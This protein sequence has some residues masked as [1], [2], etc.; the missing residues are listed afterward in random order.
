MIVSNRAH[1]IL[2]R[3]V[4]FI[5]IGVLVT[6]IVFSQING[7]LSYYFQNHT[8]GIIALIGIVIMASIRINYFSYEDEYEIIHIHSKS[9]IFGN[10]K[11]PTQT[12]YEFPKRII[13]DYEFKKG[14]LT[15]RLTISLLTQHGVKRVRKFNLTFVPMQKLRYVV[16]SLESIRNQNAEIAKEENLEWS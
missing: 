10:F 2:W 5:F 9:L 3:I 12:R 13:Y 8:P 14:L 6:D 16:N 11:A 7:S 4:L 1:F 15:K